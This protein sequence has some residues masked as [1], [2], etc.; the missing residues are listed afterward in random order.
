MTRLYE[1]LAF[2]LL[3]L[4][5]YLVFHAAVEALDRPLPE[6]SQEEKARRRQALESY[7]YVVR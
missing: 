4:F 1:A 5:G 7:G 3:L 6:V 2:A